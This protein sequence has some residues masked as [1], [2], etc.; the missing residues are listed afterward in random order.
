LTEGYLPP[1]SGSGPTPLG[2]VYATVAFENEKA[3]STIERWEYSG[4]R[5]K[6]TYLYVRA[7][8][9]D[10][11]GTYHITVTD[12]LSKAIARGQAAITKDFFHP[13]MP[14]I[15]G[16]DKPVSPWEGIALPGVDSHGEVAFIEPGRPR[17]DGFP[18]FCRAM[19]SRI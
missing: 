11:I 18:R 5:P 16:L 3:D 4:K 12:R 7:I 13:W 17:R 10:Q 9:A 8:A 1:T 19:K 2:P 15:K 14:W 6:G